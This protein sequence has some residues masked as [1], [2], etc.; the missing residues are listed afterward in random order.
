MRFQAILDLVLP[1]DIQKRACKEY[2]AGSFGVLAKRL[3]AEEGKKGAPQK[4][5]YRA[6]P[7]WT[8]P[9]LPFLDFSVLPRKNPQINQGLLSPAK[10]TK[11]LEN[12]QRKHTN[13]QGNPLL[14][15][16][17]GIP[18]NQGKEGQGSG[19]IRANRFARFARI[20]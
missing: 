5:S 19:V 13:N 14:K 4:G 16:N 18:K 8:Y 7:I 20:G 3:Q 10:P 12:Y 15:I 17:Q 2:E 6:S 9:V 11:T 1:A